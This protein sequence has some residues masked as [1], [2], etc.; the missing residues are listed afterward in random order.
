M[1]G[2][3]QVLWRAAMISHMGKSHI[4]TGTLAPSQRHRVSYV[5]CVKTS[6][7]LNSSGS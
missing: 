6:G 5:T 2:A 3:V 7:G 4:K 1:K